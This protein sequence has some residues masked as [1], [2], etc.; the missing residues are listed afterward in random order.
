M[1][2][3]R[4]PGMSASPMTEAKIQMEKHMAWAFANTTGRFIYNC[5]EWY[6][7]S[8][9]DGRKMQDYLNQWNEEWS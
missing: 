8:A 4:I 7:E 5:S 6:F 9:D 1:F 3:V 2:K